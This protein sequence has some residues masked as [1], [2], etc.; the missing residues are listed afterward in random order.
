MLKHKIEQKLSEWKND[1][2][3]NP[4]IIKGPRQVGK[5]FSVLD[6][7]NKNYHSVIYLNFIENPIYNS[8]FKGSLEVDNIIMLLSAIFGRSSRQMYCITSSA[9]QIHPPLTEPYVRY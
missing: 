3:H 7:A 6:F 5:T 1:F 4:L 2:N 8:V 9:T